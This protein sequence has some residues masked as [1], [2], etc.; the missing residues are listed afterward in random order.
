MGE[1]KIHVS[2]KTIVEEPNGKIFLRS[3]NRDT[4]RKPIGI[5]LTSIVKSLKK[6]EKL[7]QMTLTN[8]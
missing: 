5:I 6:S 2:H 7:V 1:N 4:R 8:K 3:K